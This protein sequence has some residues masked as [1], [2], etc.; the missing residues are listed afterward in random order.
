MKHFWCCSL[1]CMKLIYG[2]DKTL[3]KLADRLNCRF[4]INWYTSTLQARL[5]FQK[6]RLSSSRAS[7][8]WPQSPA[9][10][11][12]WKVTIFSIRVYRYITRLA[13]SSWW[14]RRYFSVRYVY[15]HRACTRTSSLWSFFFWKIFLSWKNV[16]IND[17]VNS[18]VHFVE[19]SFPVQ[20][21]CY[22]T[23]LANRY[24]LVHLG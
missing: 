5:V 11:C 6:L 2:L 14:A 16:D 7:F 18:D 15:L 17:R 23:R 24:Y 10:L 22:I 19:E 20:G 21:N 12:R 8:Q 13:E 3:I 1:L 9:T 4:Q